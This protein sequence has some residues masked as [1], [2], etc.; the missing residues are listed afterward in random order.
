MDV[1]RVVYRQRRNLE[2]F[3]TAM[4]ELIELRKE[5]ASEDAD[6]ADPSSHARDRKAELA[7]CMAKAVWHLILPPVCLGAKAMS[8]ADK[9]AAVLHALR[10]LS[11]SWQMCSFLLG[12]VVAVCS[13]IGTESKLGSVPEYDAN[14]LFPHWDETA[15][16]DDTADADMRMVSISSGLCSLQRA[17]IVMGCEHICHNIE[18]TVTKS[19]PSFKRWFALAS[20][21]T[22]FLDGTFYTTR[23]SHTIF[24][25]CGAEFVNKRCV[26]FNQVP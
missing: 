23:M 14:R 24:N 4:E 7:G 2:S 3:V 19:L 15:L 10:L 9:F 26:A 1:G 5:A 21:L 6:G 11:C 12:R 25:V 22:R 16:V 8:L 18:A 13:D 20:N 17:L